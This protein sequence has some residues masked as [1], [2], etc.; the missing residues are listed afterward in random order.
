MAGKSIL[1]ASILLSLFCLNNISFAA[2]PPTF[3]DWT[4]YA[5]DGD[6]WDPANWNLCDP[7]LLEPDC[8]PNQNIYANIGPSPFNL[9]VTGDPC[10]AGLIVYMASWEFA[11]DIVEMTISE[12]TGLFNCGAIITISQSTLWPDHGI[13]NMY[14]GTVYTPTA[15]SGSGGL[16]IGNVLY[17]YGLLNIYGGLMTVPRIQ[18]NHGTANLYGGV[19]ENTSETS[20]ALII[21]ES[22]AMN[23][24]NVA[25]GTLRLAG[26]RINEIYS[27]SRI[28]PYENR[29]YLV[30]DYNVSTPGYTTVTAV[31]DLGVTFNPNPA[32]TQSEVSISPNLTWSSGDYVQDVNEHQVYFGT[33]F[34]DVNDAN[35]SN[36]LGV[37]QGFRDVNNFSPAGLLDTNTTY[38]WRIDEVNDAN[39]NSPWKG[40]VWQFTTQLCPLGGSDFTGNLND[41]CIVDLFDLKIMCQEWLTPG[42]SADIYPEDTPDGI[43]DFSDFAV[44]ANNWLVEEY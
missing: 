7:F 5:G 38:Y 11:P 22:H 23:K 41:D 44:L 31:Y 29:G 12:T 18:I 28:V 8:I 13:I 39:T 15:S 32:H 27:S 35:V 37:Y 43:V 40:N 20:T 25:G 16:L 34:A 26:D 36:P 19:L 17:G 33:S 4:G 21:S 6:W 9:N 10:C 30:V 2:E 42:A 14:G 1:I 24:I 3:A